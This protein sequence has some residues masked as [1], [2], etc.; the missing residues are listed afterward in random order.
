[1]HKDWMDTT[2]KTLNLFI[3]KSIVIK[4]VE[5]IDWSSTDNYHP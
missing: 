5:I 1:M 2:N 3:L 4:I